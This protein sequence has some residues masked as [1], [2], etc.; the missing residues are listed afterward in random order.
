MLF[1]KLYIPGIHF[2]RRCRNRLVFIQ[3]AMA[4]RY[5]SISQIAVLWHDTLVIDK[6]PGSCTYTPLCTPGFRKARLRNR[7]RKNKKSKTKDPYIQLLW[8]GWGGWRLSG[9]MTK[10]IA[11]KRN[12]RYH[13]VFY[14]LHHSPLQRALHEQWSVSRWLGFCHLPDS[15]SIT[16]LV[17]VYFKSLCV[18]VER[19]EFVVTF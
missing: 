10:V 16:Y 3:R 18:D 12:Y 17:V 8:G 9:I 13:N 14:T 2:I 15:N 4:L 7:K 6:S 1:Q 11:A 19:P 5:R